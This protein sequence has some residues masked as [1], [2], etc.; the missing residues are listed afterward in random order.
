MRGGIVPIRGDH[1][2]R[3]R[4][5]FVSARLGSSFARLIDRHGMDGTMKED[6]RT[7]VKHEFEHA[8]P[9]VIHDPEQDMTVLARWLHRAMA[10]G[11][12]FWYL[13]FG[14]VV[15]AVALTVLSNGL[16]RGKSSTGQAWTELF[17]AQTPGQRKEIAEANPNTPVAHAAKLQAATSYLTMA[18]QDLPNNREAATPQL[19]QALELFKQ[20]AAEAPKDSPEA[21]AAAFGAA[22]ALEARNELPEAIEQYKAVIAGW[23]NS[24]E[25]KHAEKLAAELKRPEAI[26]FYR[27]LYTYKPPVAPSPSSLPG[28]G[29]LPA[30]HPSLSGP[31]VPAGPLSTPTLP[32]MEG[33]RTSPGTG[34]SP[35]T[36]PGPAP[37]DLPPPPLPPAETKTTRPE[38]PA[39]TDPTSKP[40]T[41]PEKP[42]AKDTLPSDPFAPATPPAQPKA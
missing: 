19:G 29:G 30:G 13:L 1:E 26:E 25:A 23:P 5:A 7:P 8:A 10:K 32:G 27:Q 36:G 28:I 42:A 12:R 18:V 24:A 21:V 38:P 22:R 4:P 17:L 31:T 9:T 39:K 40:A 34:T 11:P 2:D 6:A 20:V 15:V 41:T 14:V 33:F 37:F 3:V 16:S 35:S